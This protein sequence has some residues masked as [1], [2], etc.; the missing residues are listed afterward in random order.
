MQTCGSVYYDVCILYVV[1]GRTGDASPA[2]YACLRLAIYPRPA[3]RDLNVDKTGGRGG[4]VATSTM[5][6]PHV[7]R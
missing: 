7:Y 2:T 3:L 4:R 6:F 5:A 1:A